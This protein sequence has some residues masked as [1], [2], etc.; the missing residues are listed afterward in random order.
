MKKEDSS[1]DPYSKWYDSIVGEKGH[2]FHREVILPCLKRFFAFEKTPSPS[3][4]D[5]GCGQ[6][7]LAGEIPEKVR[8]VG[9]D[10]G[11]DL[12]SIAKRNHKGKVF[13]ERDL[14][15]PLHLD[16]KPFTHAIFLLSLQNME[17]LEM[18]ISNGAKY[19]APGG[20]LFLVMNHPCFRI[21]RQTST[22]IDE[23]SKSQYRRVNVYH[24]PMSIPIQMHPGKEASLVSFSYHHPLEDY[25]RALKKGSLVVEELEELYST[26]LSVG[27]HAKM[28][29]R[30]RKEFPYFLIMIAKKEG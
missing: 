3:L 25:F 8:Y 13:Y 22:E 9:V 23:K 15:K 10:I 17:N 18:A 11:K 30:M 24:S 5:L 4:L 21:P 28:E 2:F 20:R 16:E 26:K 1:W 6:G 12:L 14:T 19:L 7:F 29:N 27:K